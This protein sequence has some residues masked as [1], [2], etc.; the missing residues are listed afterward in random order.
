MIT[1]KQKKKKKKNWN[2]QVII[3]QT[4]KQWMVQQNDN[5]KSFWWR[6]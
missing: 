3:Y 2:K 5:G 1:E 4:V 6:I